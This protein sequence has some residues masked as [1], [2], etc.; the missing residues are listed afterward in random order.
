M[1]DQTA[2][3]PFRMAP[4]HIHAALA[5][6]LEDSTTKPIFTYEYEAQIY[7]VELP[8]VFLNMTDEDGGPC[9]VMTS[10]R[11]PDEAL[12]KLWAIVTSPTAELIINPKSVKKR[13]IVRWDRY[14]WRLLRVQQEALPAA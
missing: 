1:T 4:E 14:L 5:A 2:G 6:I 12:E 13:R 10:G 9:A 8:H 11:G 7:R 3:M